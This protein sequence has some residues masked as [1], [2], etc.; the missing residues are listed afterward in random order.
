MPNLSKRTTITDVARAAGVSV[1]SVSNVLNGTRPV[2]GAMRA[3]VEEVAVRLGYTASAVAQTLRRRRSM[4]IGL[5]MTAVSTA[6]MRAIA[7]ALDGIAA[8]HGYELL[9]VHSHQ[10]PERELHRVRSL[11]SL[12]ADGI[13]LVPSLAPERALDAIATDG[14]PAVVVDR[15][16]EDARF[17]YVALDNR[18]AMRGVIAHFV[19][20]GHRRMLLVAQN[21]AVIT[22]RHR[23]EGIADEMAAHAGAVSCAAIER[24][25]DPDALT[26]RLGTILAAADPPTAIVAGNSD[27][28]I[29]L[30][31]ALRGLGVCYPDDVALATFDDPDWA[32]ALPVEMTTLES[33]TEEIARVVW[34]AL[35][36]QIE[37]APHVPRTAVIS[38]RL[39]VRASSGPMAS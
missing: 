34:A 6:Y 28:A 35:S 1:A 38:S 29:S 39:M 11:L 9:Q 8:M 18:R 19:A 14:R 25:D 33:P 15:I 27:V 4:T 26:A 30:L 10:D 32:R 17:D 36:A 2:S 24:G 7:Q 5:C 16:C 12:Q 22:T 37:G 3:R 31:R 21:L 13:V 20:R 23:L